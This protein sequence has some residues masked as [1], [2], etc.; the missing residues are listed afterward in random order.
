MAKYEYT[1]G[2]DAT[3]GSGTNCTYNIYIDGVYATSGT[4]Q[5]SPAN[6]TDIGK[7][8]TIISMKPYNPLIDIAYSNGVLINTPPPAASAVITTFDAAPSTNPS[9]PESAGY[10]MITLTGT[11]IGNVIISRNGVESGTEKFTTATWSKVDYFLW[12]TGTWS[13]TAKDSVKT[14]TKS[15]TISSGTPPPSTCPLLNVP[16]LSLLISSGLPG[17]SIGFTATASGGQTTGIAYIYELNLGTTLV[18]TSATGKGS[19]YSGTFIVPSITIGTYNAILTV[20]DS[21]VPQQARIS[22]PVSFTVTNGTTPPPTGTK[23][24]CDDGCS[25]ATHSTGYNDQISC[26]TGCAGTP[27]PT[28]T[29]PTGKINIPGLGCQDKNTVMMAGAAMFLFMMMKK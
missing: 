10:G 8:D 2:C 29:C 6:C 26:I 27:P 28:T 18:H 1:W 22:T 3:C 15:V 23:W 20:K 14:V 5:V 16:T 21:C 11:G 12:G 9:L 25:I 17:A 7:R 4:T 13:I 19:N 24:N